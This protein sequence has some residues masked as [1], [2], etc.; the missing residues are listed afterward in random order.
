MANTDHGVRGRT[1]GRSIAAAALVLLLGTGGRAETVL[2]FGNAREAS[3]PEAAE[4][5]PVPFAY[6]EPPRAPVYAP[7]APARPSIIAP[8]SYA[9][10]VRRADNIM[11][12]NLEARSPSRGSVSPGTSLR[13]ILPDAP[14]PAPSP[15]PV[16]SSPSFRPASPPRL[17]TEP[18]MPSSASGDLPG[19]REALARA[20]AALDLTERVVPPP[21]SSGE[22]HPGIAA[23]EA[24]GA[25]V[26]TSDPEA[27]A[28]GAGTPASDRA[29]SA[30]AP[31]Q[32]GTLG[33]SRRVV[34]EIVPSASAQGNARTAGAIHSGRMGLLLAALGA[35][36]IVSWARLHR[37]PAPRLLDE[38]HR[39]DAGAIA[40]AARGAPLTLS[41]Y[42][43]LIATA[44][45]ATP[46]GRGGSKRSSPIGFHDAIERRLMARRF[47]P[48][49]EEFE[50]ED[51]R[52]EIEGARDL[53]AEGV[54]PRTVQE[55]TGA[56]PS[57]VRLLESLE[58]H[59]RAGAGI[60]GA[61]RRGGFEA[62]SGQAG[63]PG[64]Q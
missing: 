31:S 45:L 32:R 33:R 46:L 43:T 50:S 17:P 61:G 8:A 18:P 62:T 23:E 56:R 44:R 39:G 38:R 30:P 20:E 60:A 6:P 29:A 51:G 7:R 48:E 10:A 42:D 58:R 5:S 2:D 41:R 9:G 37:R 34:P 14:A 24:S 64:L 13:P 35:I 3:P 21:A 12:G 49:G 4:A 53:L 19:E 26:P 52:E 59:A 27:P 55:V 25:S 57:E 28:D 11:R 47:G 15:A 36:G 63:Y 22:A 40:R 54:S 16:A 1:Q